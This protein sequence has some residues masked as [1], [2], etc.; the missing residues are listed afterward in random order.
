MREPLNVS[1]H[2]VFVIGRTTFICEKN[3]VP[4]E[5]LS[6]TV[7]D[8]IYQDEVAKGVELKDVSE[9]DDYANDGT[10]TKDTADINLQ[11]I[12][13][14]M[15]KDSINSSEESNSKVEVV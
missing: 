11:E 15:G 14:E 2:L 12:D 1:H 10:T 13:S 5:M 6:V 4:N 8:E 3:S 7:N 9:I